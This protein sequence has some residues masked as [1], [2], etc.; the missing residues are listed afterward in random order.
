MDKA[1][2]QFLDTVLDQAHPARLSKPLRDKMKA[3]LA[4][5]LDQRLHEAVLLSLSD[6]DQVTY[7]QQVLQ[8]M[9][10]TELTPWLTERIPDFAELSQ[11]ICREFV[12]DYLTVCAQPQ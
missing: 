6:A 5:Q 12:R 3:D 9:A 10:I 8:G 1:L 7:Q 2:D 4:I 11:F